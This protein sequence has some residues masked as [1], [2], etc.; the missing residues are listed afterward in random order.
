[1]EIQTSADPAVFWLRARLFLIF[2][3]MGIRTSSGEIIGSLKKIQDADS[4]D[5]H[6]APEWKER[7]KSRI[8]GLRSRLLLWRSPPESTRDDLDI[9]VLLFVPN[10]IVFAPWSV[11]LD[12]GEPCDSCQDTSDEAAFLRIGESDVHQQPKV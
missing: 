11:L 9:Y 12:R 5:S 10:L 7:Q 1:M 4:A 6:H 8:E 2:K 3:V